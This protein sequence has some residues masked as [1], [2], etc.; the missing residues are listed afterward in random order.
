M[1][2]PLS[3]HRVLGPGLLSLSVVCGSACGSS[4]PGTP[5]GDA[6]AADGGGVT[7]EGVDL[8]ESAEHCGRCG[9]SCGSAACT[10]GVCELQLLKEM[11]AG[12]VIQAQALNG[13]L[14]FNVDDSIQSLSATNDLR[15]FGAYQNFFATSDRVFAINTFRNDLDVI[16]LASG[17]AGKIVPKVDTPSI[18]EIREVVSDGADLYLNVRHDNGT[19]GTAI[20]RVPSAPGNPVPE[21]VYDSGGVKQSGAVLRLFVDQGTVYFVGVK[22]SAFGLYKLDDTVAPVWALSCSRFLDVNGG[23][24]AGFRSES[25]LEVRAADGA[26]SKFDVAATEQGV[27]FGDSVYLTSVSGSGGDPTQWSATVRRVPL[28]GKPV[29][30]LKQVDLTKDKPANDT[31]PARGELHMARD[32]K[33]IYWALLQGDAR[34][35]DKT[36]RL[37]KW[38]P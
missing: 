21:L 27:I 38:V 26:V 3:L 23:R 28:D 12:S 6:G 14:Y 19:E 30:V 5:S 25:V 36:L 7:C 20:H 16:P 35:A 1:V 22:S 13:T 8:Q 4:N 15:N 17:E 2:A 18:G 32:D 31:A 37:W 34:S 9:H 29:E 33:A 11:R 24:A 10:A